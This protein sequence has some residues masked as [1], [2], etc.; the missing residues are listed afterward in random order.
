MG[1]GRTTGPIVRRAAGLAADLIVSALYPQGCHVCGRAVLHRAG[2]VA[3]L[4]CWADPRVTPL[5]SGLA[6]CSRCGLP[7]VVDCPE[8]RGGCLPPGVSVARSAGAY[9]GA[10]RASLLD[11][12]HRPRVVA[13]LGRAFATAAADPALAA[14]DV[15][16]PVPLH[17]R[18]RA[19]RGHNQAELLARAAARAVMLEPAA[20]A[21]V[22]PAPRLRSGLDREARLG[23]VA[24]AFRGAPRLVAGRTVL[25][26]DD[27]FTTGATLAACAE[28][29]RRAGAH[30]VLALTAARTLA[31]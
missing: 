29:L 7:G 25:L 21:R 22:A 26:V 18:R 28:A 8:V 13:E 30:D 5:W 3:C 20:L 9:A 14:A 11:L 19:E 12:K 1:I 17:P 27:V 2:G 16:V 15:L 6:G 24:G 31:P 4:A 10:L 23:A